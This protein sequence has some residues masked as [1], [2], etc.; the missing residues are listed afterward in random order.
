MQRGLKKMLKTMFKSYSL[1]PIK[2][3]TN[4]NINIRPLLTTKK[5][6][7]FCALVKK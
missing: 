7:E 1:V 4:G 2:I 3:K 5:F 6:S